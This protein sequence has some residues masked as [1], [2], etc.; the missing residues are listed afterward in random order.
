MTANETQP[1][2]TLARFVYRA[3]SSVADDQDLLRLAR[4][5]GSGSPAWDVLVGRYGRFV[6]T[7][8]RRQLRCPSEADDATQ[9][10]F[11]LLFR[12]LS[13]PTNPHIRSLSAWLSRVAFRVASRRRKRGDRERPLSSLTTD[14]PHPASEDTAQLACVDTSRM[15]IEELSSLP[16]K[17][18]TAIFETRFNGLSTAAAADR[19]DTRE[20]TVRK[21]IERGMK[22]LEAGLRKRGVSGVTAVAVI[23]GLT[24]SSVAGAQPARWVEGV[25][26]ESVTGPDAGLT[27]QSLLAEGGIGVWSKALG[28]GGLIALAAVGAAL[29]WPNSSRNTPPSAPLVRVEPAETNEVLPAPARVTKFELRLWRPVAD[30]N[31]TQYL[32]EIKRNVGVIPVVQDRIACEVSL[33][34]EAPCLLFQVLPDGAIRPCAPSDPNERPGISEE[35]RYPSLDR[36]G[37]EK[38]T[39][40]GNQAFVLVV[41][42]RPEPFAVWADRFGGSVPWER[43]NGEGLWYVADKG[44]PTL[45]RP[46]GGPLIQPNAAT[47]EPLNKLCQFLRGQENVESVRAF[48]FNPRRQQPKK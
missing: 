20:S 32:G 7:I 19:L 13:E 31:R 38:L 25:R 33:D 43:L 42:T 22:R 23:G 26:A 30:E 16:E 47:A 3:A 41:Q 27:A 48:G 2:A 39:E 18:Q 45:I 6:W 35:H 4:E 29:L 46:L 36:Y 12:T 21:W 17:Y 1:G 37:E 8:C 28:V 11:F 5:D 34:R 14:Q 15:V 10:T 24:A 9:H 40:F 44:L